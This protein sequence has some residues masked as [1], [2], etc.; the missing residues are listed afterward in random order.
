[1]KATRR[2]ADAGKHRKGD[3]NWGCPEMR[4]QRP[5][6]QQAACTRFSAAQGVP[7]TFRSGQ[8]GPRAPTE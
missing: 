7:A 3:C 8:L 4:P 2:C 1:M 6:R 5:R